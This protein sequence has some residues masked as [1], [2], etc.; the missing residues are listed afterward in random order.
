MK[1][2][3]DGEK[4]FMTALIL[5]LVAIFIGLFT[6]GLSSVLA[7]EGTMPPNI[8]EEGLT[9]APVDKNEALGFL[10]KSVENAVAIKP[11]LDSADN[12]EVDTD[13]L[14]ISGSDELKTAMLYAVDEFDSQLDSNFESVSTDFGEEIADKLNIPA[15]SVDDIIDYQCDYIFYQCPSCGEESSEELPNCELCG[16]V[17]PYNKKYRDE[18]TVT[19]TVAAN[20]K[21]LGGN[22]NKRSPEE[23]IALCGDALNGLADIEN[24]NI[25][26]EELKIV[27]RVQRLTDKLTYLDYSKKM[28]VNTDVNFLDKYASLGKVSTAFVIEENNSYSFTWPELSLSAHEMTVEP[29]GTDNLLA[30]L[31]CSNPLEYKATWSSSDESILTVDEEGYFKAGKTEGE[32][33]I[34]AS[35]E[36][37]GQTYTDE[38]LVKVKYSVESSKMSDKDIELNVG[39]SETL[40][41]KISPDKA[42]VKTVKWYTEDEKI[43]VVDENGVVTAVAPGVV[44]V[45]S[46][47]DDGYYKSSCE[48]TVK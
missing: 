6:Y 38:C 31:T 13:T 2:K 33:M 42:T 37:N 8:L 9:P 14:E 12:F 15:I 1:K 10:D 16:G 30:T 7:M 21:T 47:T 22:F 34:T 23:A 3:I 46:L 11:K 44:T 29:K 18:Y 48:V 24:L 45:Y 32:A 19:L 41:V 17:N 40:E 25:T 35:F 5:A 27:F 26:Y 36:F 43:A 20:E 39:E 4:L 28:K